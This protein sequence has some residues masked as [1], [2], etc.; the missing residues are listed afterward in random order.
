MQPFLLKIWKQFP[1]WLKILSARLLRPKYMV[2]VAAVI[3]DEHGNILLG[4]H[5]Y[6]KNHPWGLLAGSLEYGEDPEEAIVRE[7]REETGCEIE[8][9]RLLKA[10]SAKEDHHVSLIYLCRIVGGIFQPSPEISTVGIFPFDDLPNILETERVLIAELV[11]Q[12]QG[13]A[14]NLDVK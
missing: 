2:A 11:E 14:K 13:A 10:V 1:L 8:V 6:R 3:F 9:Q 4:K 5:T 12:L 7:L